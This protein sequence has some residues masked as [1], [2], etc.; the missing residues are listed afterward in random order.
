MKKIILVPA[1]LGVMGIGG[2]IAV[3]GGNIVGSADTS[4]VLT[5]S[6]IEKKALAEIEGKI[7]EIVFDKEGL[8]NVYE[9][10]IVTADAEYDFKFDATSGELLK[11]R[12]DDEYHDVKNSNTNASTNTN[13]ESNS[14]IQEDDGDDWYDDDQYDD[15]DDQDNLDDRYDDDDHD[16]DDRYDD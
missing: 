16:D 1:L 14:T 5:K 12:K 13:T 3:A 11:K 8:L 7:T 2:I 9:V 15:D 6:Q 10:E 4:V